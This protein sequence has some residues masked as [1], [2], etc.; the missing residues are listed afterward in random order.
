GGLM[1]GAALG[2]VVSRIQTPVYE[3]TTEV[4][5]SRA[6]LQ[7]STDMLPLDENQLVFT[8]IRLV[9][10]RPVLD[11][12]S[13][14]LGSKIKVDNIEV[15]LIPDTL[16]IQIKVQD[17]DARRAAAIANTLVQVLI[18]Q[19]ENLVA[20][21]Y[22]DFESSLKVQMDQIQKQIS[23][24][25]SQISQIN[26]AG[27]LEQLTQVNL[28]IDQLKSQIASLENEVNNYPV[29]MSDIQ[30]ATLREKQAQ[31]EQLRSLQS[32]YQQ[33]QINL[34][35]VGK[36]GQTGLTRDDPRLDSLEAT[37]NLYQQ[38]YLKLAN[39]RETVNMDRVQNTPHITQI[40]P[41]VPPKD[42]V[43]PLPLLY[44]VLGGVVGLILS[45]TAV[46]MVDQFGESLK[47][48]DQTEGLFHVPVLGVVSDFYSAKGD[49]V[50]SYD[51]A[52]MEAEAFRSLC[53]NIDFTTPKKSIH[54]LLVMNADP[55]ESKTTVATNLGVVNAQQGKRVILLD[56]DLK[57]P[58]LHKLFGVENRVGLANI[59]ETETDLKSASH[60]VE[61]VEGLTFISGGVVRENLTSW[62]N[63]EKWQELLVKLQKQADLVIID[64]PSIEVAETQT[65]ASKADA[66]L[67]VIRLRET[68]GE[69]VKAALRQFQLVGGKVAGIVFFRSKM[70]RTRFSEILHW[71]R[72]YK[73]GEH[74]KVTS[75]FEDTS[76]PLP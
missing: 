73:K 42:P 51:P 47:T 67:L 39:S 30:R 56:G 58:H 24:L 11:A 15:N 49:L 12:A 36:P 14:Q 53:I 70:H 5:I 52:S 23:G 18:Q 76:I 35:F 72:L 63:R 50:T 3:A 65:L 37:L 4:L 21:R 19:N 54:T 43:R 33:I 7:T 9:K 48:I 6:R 8:N 32:L 2:F 17:P 55:K 13:S 34:T 1:L 40:N 64:G 45:F 16:I 74:R 46:L 61:G 69:S 27:I 75:Q 68:R 20:G 41:A 38:L 57:Q 31:L 59:L 25:Q 62:R 10:S 44:M 66:V 71:A 29:Y 60:S 22:T 28:E 26:D